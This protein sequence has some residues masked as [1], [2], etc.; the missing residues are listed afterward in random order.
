MA[1]QG[2]ARQGKGYLMRLDR[3][4]KLL[5]LAILLE[6]LAFIL[7]SYLLEWMP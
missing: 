4:S 3:E 1:R 5:I 7:V 6:V 2:T